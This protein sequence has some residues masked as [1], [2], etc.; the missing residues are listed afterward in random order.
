MKT[1]LAALL[2][3]SGVAGLSSA[4]VAQTVLQACGPD[5]QRYC[6]NAGPGHLKQCMKKH[7]KEL[8]PTCIGTLVK[9]KQGMAQ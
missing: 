3:I 6:P 7:M 4:A 9:K 2:M 1:Y 8:S 5:I